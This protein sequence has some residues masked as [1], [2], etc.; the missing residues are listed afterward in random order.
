MSLV[1]AFYRDAQREWDRL[2]IPL[3][4]IELA[5]TLDLI[6]SYFK[7]GD[8][9]ADI[10]GGPGRY[11]IELLRRGCRATLFELS[12]ENVAFADAKV[13]EMGLTADAFLVGDARDLSV[14]HGQHFDGILALGPLYHLAER[15]ERIVFLKEAK[16]LLHPNGILIASY[17]NAWGIA[18]SLLTDAP[19]W[20]ADS[21]NVACLMTG[22]S[23]VGAYACSGFTECHWSTP[24]DALAEMH[25]AGFIVL[26]EVGAEGFASGARDAIAAIAKDSPAALEQIIALGVATS[27][28][29]QYR[30]STDHFLMVGKV[31]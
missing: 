26:E 15:N 25:E 14:L 17:L 6:D 8:R 16:S 7:N 9:V 22:A 2:D 12:P 29:A 11:M 27:R 28:L 5:T 23:F 18:R 20:F 4:R 1:A 3:F 31:P 19:L 10:G 13:A 24:D 21:K 30:R